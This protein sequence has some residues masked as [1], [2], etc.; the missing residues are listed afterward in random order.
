MIKIQYKR[1]RTVKEA[2]RKIIELLEN[3][4][5]LEITDFEINKSLEYGDFIIAIN[6]NKI[7]P[8]GKIK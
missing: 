1:V 4:P 6:V 7:N 3:Y 8:D 2:K 5:Q